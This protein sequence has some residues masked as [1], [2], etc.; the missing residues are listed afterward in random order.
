M[1]YTIDVFLIQYIYFMKKFIL[2]LALT[3]LSFSLE[4][5]ITQQDLTLEQTTGTTTF[6]HYT[7]TD[8]YGVKKFVE[9]TVDEYAVLGHQNH[10]YDCL[11]PCRP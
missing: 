10:I 11:P 3:L 7:H 5:S 9:L 4:S 2:I 6:F 8:A 1:Y